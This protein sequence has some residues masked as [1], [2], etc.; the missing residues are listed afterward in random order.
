[1]LLLYNEVQDLKIEKNSKTIEKSTKNNNNRQNK[2]CKKI[3]LD[4]IYRR[5]NR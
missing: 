5:E 3:F 2:H 1:M 4:Y